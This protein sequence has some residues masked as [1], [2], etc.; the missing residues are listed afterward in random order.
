MTKTKVSK[1]AAKAEV[2]RRVDKGNGD[3][4]PP[5]DTVPAKLAFSMSTAEL[6]EI[7]GI[8]VPEIKRVKK[9]TTKK[10]KAKK[11]R[12]PMKVKAE[13]DAN[14]TGATPGSA[15]WW[16]AYRASTAKWRED[17]A[18][19]KERPDLKAVVGN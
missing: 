5:A 4:R 18:D 19:E 9:A 7:A 1:A 11:E 16:T 14:A 8:P 12:S 6:C 3:Y 15:D 10:G 13:A 17:H 2:E